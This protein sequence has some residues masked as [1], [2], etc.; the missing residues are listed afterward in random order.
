MKAKKSKAVPAQ[1]KPLK[2]NVVMDPMVTWPYPRPTLGQND[3]NRLAPLILRVGYYLQLLQTTKPDAKHEDAL[4]DVVD[5][6]IG[7]CL[8]A[9][10]AYDFA[11]LVRNRMNTHGHIRG[12]WDLIIRMA[13]SGAGNPESE[14]DPD[15]ARKWF[16]VGQYMAAAETY[17][18]DQLKELSRWLKNV[19]AET[20]SEEM[21]ERA[22]KTKCSL[23]DVTLALL[24]EQSPALWQPSVVDG[25]KPRFNGREIT[26]IQ[27]N[28][29]VVL[30]THGRGERGMSNVALVRL[31]G[32]SSARNTVRML[33][34]YPETKPF[35][36]SNGRPRFIGKYAPPPRDKLN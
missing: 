23:L 14:P 26:L 3:Q 10:R 16:F 22:H 24:N 17:D 27:Y 18:S 11:T 12:G 2:E 33:R 35:I 28:T 34:K 31:V 7:A 8:P 13:S 36:N 9:T 29:L 25:Q 5:E 32:S 19:V 15:P 4:R 30:A 6:L 1:I 21:R 20:F